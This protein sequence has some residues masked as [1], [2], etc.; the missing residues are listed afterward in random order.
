MLNKKIRVIKDWQI[1]CKQNDTTE[2]NFDKG[3]S[4]IKIDE[5]IDKIK[6]K[7]MATFCGNRKYILYGS[8][9][10]GCKYYYT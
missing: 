9:I 3:L 2:V 7:Y 8:Y 4:D 6:N 5:V 1:V 10:I